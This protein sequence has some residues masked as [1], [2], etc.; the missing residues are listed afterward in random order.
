[1]VWLQLLLPSSA[2]GTQCLR[3]R[4]PAVTAASLLARMSAGKYLGM[5]LDRSDLLNRFNNLPPD[6][7]R[8]E[9]L[10]CCSSPAW[11]ERMTSGRPY[12]SSHDA[13]RQSSAIVAGLTVTDLAEALASA[14]CAAAGTGGTDAETD[15]AL[16]E[17]NM[18][19]ERRF[20]HVYLVCQSGR[21]GQQLLDLMRS[22][23]RNDARA[24]WQV[25]RAEL[26]K[27]NEIRLRKLLAG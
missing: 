11:A 9:M 2:A 20:G 17:S 25:V 3:R 10:S 4:L 14:P 24:E 23:L 13:V 1:M 27:V 16:S 12:S 21:S 19:Y 15:R 8:A 7:A 5:G 6:V 18:E 22:R 26:Q